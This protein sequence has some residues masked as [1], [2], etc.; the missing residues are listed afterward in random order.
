MFS[1]C[2]IRLRSGSKSAS[3][4]EHTNQ[5]GTVEKSG[6]NVLLVKFNVKFEED[7]SKLLANQLEDHFAPARARIEIDDDY[8]LPRSQEKVSATERNRQ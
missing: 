2:S 1:I 7:G 5:F 3:S 8:L 6:Y 4:D